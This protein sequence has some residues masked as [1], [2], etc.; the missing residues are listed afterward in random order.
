[1]AQLIEATSR[2]DAQGAS[3]AQLYLER[4]YKLADEDYIGLQQVEK[5]IQE[6]QSGDGQTG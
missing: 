6:L 4:C 2:S 5:A 3:L 1:M